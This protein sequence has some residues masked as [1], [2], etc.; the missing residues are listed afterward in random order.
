MRVDAT[1]RTSC[2]EFTCKI[3]RLFETKPRCCRKSQRSSVTTYW[4]P[5]VF[6]ILSGS[7]STVPTYVAGAM[8]ASDDKA[9]MSATTQ[10]QK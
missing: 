1:S 2:N 8:L 10:E 9:S 7:F 6:F 5:G 4:R 3:R